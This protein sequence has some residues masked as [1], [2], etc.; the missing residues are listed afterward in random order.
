LKSELDDGRKLNV[1]FEDQGRMTK[2]IENFEPDTTAPVE[3][4]QQG[5][6]AI[7]KNFQSYVESKH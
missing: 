4:Q 3:L 2:I 1:N 5:W 6:Q 7:L